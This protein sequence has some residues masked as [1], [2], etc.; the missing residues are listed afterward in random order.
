VFVSTV[1][2]HDGCCEVHTE[3]TNILCG[4]DSVLWQVRCV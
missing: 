1:L 3:R 2:G 4:Q